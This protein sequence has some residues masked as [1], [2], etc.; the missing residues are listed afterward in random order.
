MGIIPFTVGDGGKKCI[1][2]RTTGRVGNLKVMSQ[3][4]LRTCKYV[5][6][7]LFKRWN[8]TESKWDKA[9]STKEE[10]FKV[11]SRL[12]PDLESVFYQNIFGIT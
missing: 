10:L 2:G 1:S 9:P 7:L 12:V 4:K 8:L 11:M 6:K 3:T 5:K